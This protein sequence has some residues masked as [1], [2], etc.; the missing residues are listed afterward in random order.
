MDPSELVAS[1]GGGAVAMK[2]VDIVV[3]RFVTKA[4]ATEEA[5]AKERD[6]REKKMATKLE[7][8]ATSLADL[9]SDAKADRKEQASLVGALKK[10]EERIDAVS[11]NHRPKIEQLEQKVPV[12]E[13]RIDAL[14]QRATTL[15]TKRRR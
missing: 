10:V 2:L 6:E 15:E 9:R 5:V 13:F 1:V 4:D 7:E 3:K 12:L 14:E 8:I 11:A